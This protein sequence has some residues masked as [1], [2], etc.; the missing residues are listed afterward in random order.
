VPLRGLPQGRYTIE[1]WDTA[2]G[3]LTKRD[4]GASADGTLLLHL[5]AVETDLA[6]HIL[7]E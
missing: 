2:K 3:E 7:P 4:T 5:P 6:L 1:W